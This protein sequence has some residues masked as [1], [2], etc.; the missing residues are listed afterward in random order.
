MPLPGLTIPKTPVMI[1]TTIL[2]TTIIT[3]TITTLI[4]LTTV[5]T[6][7]T[8]TNPE[9]QAHPASPACLSSSVHSERSSAPTL[10]MTLR[11]GLGFRLSVLEALGFRI[12]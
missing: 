5:I 11:K 12:Y 6:V 4:S 7:S 1:D 3:T 8:T 9:P 2:I 10:A